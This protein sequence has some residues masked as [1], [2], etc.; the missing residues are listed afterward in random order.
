LPFVIVERVDNE[1]TWQQLLVDTGELG[2]EA[3]P[4][5]TSAPSSNLSDEEIADL[6]DASPSGVA[7]VSLNTSRV[8]SLPSTAGESQVLGNVR[9][10]E[11]VSVVAQTPDG[12]WYLI[13]Y[14]GETVWIAAFLGEVYGDTSALRVIPYPTETPE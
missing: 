5:P 1:A 9:P 7:F 8:R 6:L 12:G 14:G 4:P 11:A 2:S 10:G 13:G 3:A